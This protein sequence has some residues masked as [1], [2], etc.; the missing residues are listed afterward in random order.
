MSSVQI[1]TTVV[2]PTGWDA[3]AIRDYAR[4]KLWETEPARRRR[5]PILTE[6]QEFERRSNHTTVWRVRHTL[7][8]T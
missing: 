1:L 8:V 6:L 3:A 7:S 5:W 4:Y 2:A